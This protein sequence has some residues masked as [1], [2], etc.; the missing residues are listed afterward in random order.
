M[1]RV[2]DDYPTHEIE[3]DKIPS[4]ILGRPLTAEERNKILNTVTESFD[5]KGKREAA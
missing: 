3:E 5:G 2:R 1:A 4:V